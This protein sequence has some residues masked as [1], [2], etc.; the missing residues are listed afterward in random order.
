[1]RRWLIIGG[2]IVV[3]LVG[4]HAAAWRWVVVRAD[5]ELQAW[6]ALR[7]S[8]GWTIDMGPSRHGGWPLAAELMLPDVR[9]ISPNGAS[10]VRVS[11]SVA[12]VT[13]FVGLLQPRTVHVRLDGAMQLQLADAPAI[14]FTARLFDITTPL[15]L[16]APPSEAEVTLDDLR[17]G[18]GEQPLLTIGHAHGS[19]S[20]HL[21]AGKG[22]PALSLAVQAG[23][24]VLPS[25]PPAGA[26][27]NLWA[28]GNRLDRADLLASIDGP[29]VRA[30]SPAAWA[31]Q[32][33]DGGG[34]A[35]LQVNALDWGRLSSSGTATLSLDAGLQPQGSAT[36]RLAGFGETLDALAAARVIPPR[37]ASTAKAVLSLMARPQASGPPVVEAPLTLQDRTLQFARFPLARMPELQWS[38]AP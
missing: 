26:P 30:A 3:V 9:I 23:P 6:A 1:M 18:A 11:V 21:D 4:A 35:R 8:Q 37:T 17:L 16:Q 13:A 36:L 22:V 19:A 5:T 12:S 32:W 29:V 33:R 27:Q 2:A 38:A 31:T 20:W 7:R 14:P 34:T 24:I 28:L 15:A 10:P 25:E